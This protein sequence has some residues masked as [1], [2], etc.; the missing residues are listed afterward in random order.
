MR[1]ERKGGIEMEERE[2]R[3]A[4]FRIALDLRLE[5]K[6]DRVDALRGCQSKCRSILPSLRSIHFVHDYK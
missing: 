4:H 1:K 2:E 6:E 3:E 5:R